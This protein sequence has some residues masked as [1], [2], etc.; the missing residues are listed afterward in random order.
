MKDFFLLNRALRCDEEDDDEG[1]NRTR[2][3]APSLYRTTGVRDLELVVSR[4][5][6]ILEEYGVEPTESYLRYFL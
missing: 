3:N 1:G 2:L 6:F 4:P 5:T